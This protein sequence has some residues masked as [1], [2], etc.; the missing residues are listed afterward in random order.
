MKRMNLNAFTHHLPPRLTEA[1]LIMG[2]KDMEEVRICSERTAATVKGGV[3]LDTGVYIKKEELSQIVNSMCRG[4]MYAMQQN[5]AK[6]FITLPG[7][8]RVGVC[9]RCVSENGE[10]SLLTDISAICIRVAREVIGAADN[11]MEY[12]DFRGKLYNALIISP[13]GCGKTTVLRDAIRQLGNRHKVCVAD[14]RSEIAAC[15]GGVPTLDV[16]KFTTVM[17][18]VPKASGM[19]MMLRSMS[20]E[21][22]ATDET[23]SEEE[24]RAIYAIINAGAK[25]ITTAHGYNEKD[26]FAREHLGSLVQKGV[27]ERVFVLGKRNG[28]GTVEKIITDGRVIRNV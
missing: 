27:F 12:L 23:G 5:L 9:G 28:T 16:G 21:I 8:H 10:V 18:G 13:P 15:K 24:E 26:V 4:S 11:I 17:D 7:G 22:I 14:E 1:L 20:P 3:L 19:R 6:G 25:I 2:T